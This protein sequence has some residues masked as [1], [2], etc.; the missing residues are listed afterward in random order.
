MADKLRRRS[1]DQEYFQRLSRTEVWQH[2]IVWIAFVTLV[3]TGFM[4]K[5]PEGWVVGFF[6]K[7][8]G[9]VYAWRRFLHI[10]FAVILIIGSI[11]HVGYILLTKRGRQVLF[12]IIIMPKDLK[13]LVQ[14]VAYMWSKSFGGEE[15]E[16][17]RFDRFD[18]RE[19]LEYLFGLIGT[20]V[21]ILTGTVMT[22]S[23]LFPKIAVEIS[24]TFHICEATLATLAIAV[25]HF[26]AIHW[27]PGRFPQDTAWIDGLMSME[28]LK[29][30]HPL[31]WERVMQEKEGQKKGDIEI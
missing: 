13:Q 11:W 17:P 5:V 18:Y 14:N 19:K 8:A 31:Q 28:H 29:H 26:Y 24:A 27:K 6:G 23:S 16:K 1:E 22:F 20:T 25:W 30:E 12:D 2:N 10:L 21:I 9:S 4:S 3:A 7:Y 15:K